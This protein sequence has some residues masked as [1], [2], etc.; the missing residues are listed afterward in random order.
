M[1][2]TLTNHA[3]RRTCKRLG[4]PK[5]GACANADRALEY[6]VHQNDTKTSLHRYLDGAARQHTETPAN[7]VRIYHRA[8]YVFNDDVLI[9]VFPLP[10]KYHAVADKLEKRQNSRETY[11]T[12]AK[13]P[14]L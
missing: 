9:T 5:S 7:N 1:A 13:S 11:R 10:R 2:A 6:G 14:R 12:A 8:V 3:R 4:I